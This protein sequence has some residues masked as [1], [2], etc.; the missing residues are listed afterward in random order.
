MCAPVCASDRA[1]A[2]SSTTIDAILPSTVYHHRCTSGIFRSGSNRHSCYSESR[3][4]MCYHCV[5]HSWLQAAPAV[6]REQHNEQPSA[7][8]LSRFK[9]WASVVQSAACFDA[10]DHAQGHGN[11]LTFATTVVAEQVA[12]TIQ[13]DSASLTPQRML[14][15]MQQAL[16]RMNTVEDPN[17]YGRAVI[18]VEQMPA[19]LQQLN[20]MLL[21]PDDVS[22]TRAS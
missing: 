1:T 9:D 10:D 6:L 22:R 2:C 3:Q 4:Q 11:P 19:A 18:G 12:A 16:R 20:D 21:Q 13:H 14:R 17:P 8:L 7:H 15:F 5:A